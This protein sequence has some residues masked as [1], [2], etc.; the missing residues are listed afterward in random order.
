MN[1]NTLTQQQLVSLR[2]L[3]ENILDP[4]IL[5][6]HC[7]LDYGRH[8]IRQTGDIVM[9]GKLPL[10]IQHEVLSHV[11]IDTILTF[12]TGKSKRHGCR[13]QHNGISGGYGRSSK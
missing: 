5:L 2:I 6:K 9:F 7:P 8:M 1:N 10:E 11:N 12:T 3:N 4:K 13:Q